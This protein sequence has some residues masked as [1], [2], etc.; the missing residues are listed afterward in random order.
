MPNNEK[1]KAW[2]YSIRIGEKDRKMVETFTFTD[3]REIRRRMKQIIGEYFAEVQAK[4]Q[5]V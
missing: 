3:N 5:V 4:K 2:T 1:N